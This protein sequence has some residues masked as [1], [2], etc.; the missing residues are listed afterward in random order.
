MSNKQDTEEKLKF[1]FTY[2]DDSLPD[3]TLVSYISLLISSNYLAYKDYLKTIEKSKFSVDGYDDGQIMYIILSLGL[4][5]KNDAMQEFFYK[6]LKEARVSSYELKEFRNQINRLNDNITSTQS[7][8]GEEMYKYL[9]YI[10][11]IIAAAFYNYYLYNNGSIQ[12]LQHIYTR[13]PEIVNYMNQTG[14]KR[15]KPSNIASI[16]RRGADNPELIDAIDNAIY[17]LTTP[18]LLADQLSEFYMERENVKMIN[19]MQQTLQLL[20]GFPELAEPKETSKE[21]VLFGNNLEENVKNKLIVYKRDGVDM[22]LQETKKKLKL[23]ARMPFD[24]FKLVFESGQTSE[25]TTNPTNEPTETPTFQSIVSFVGDLTGAIGDLTPE[26]IRV[27]LSFKNTF[28]WALQDKIKQIEW[29]MQDMETNIRRQVYMIIT[30]ATRML[31]DISD[32]PSVLTLLFVLNTTAFYGII[33]LFKKLMGSNN[34]VTRLQIANANLESDAISTLANATTGIER[35]NSTDSLN[36]SLAG[37]NLQHDDDDDLNS[38]GRKRVTRRKTYKRKQT[39]RK[40]TRRKQTRRK[41]T[42]RKKVR[43]ITRKY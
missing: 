15:H 4:M 41:Q 34:R 17:C 38:G 32:I 37:M 19:Q 27:S 26:N 5:Y 20:P 14:C 11:F 24:E 8:G 36:E 31:S 1:I 25:F 40:Q 35:S 30:E 33:F 12:T 22:D 29:D 18:T 9:Y 6:I 16:L 42:R 28:L 10:G 39:R 7:G 43:R 23:L 3:F 2:L 13:G 21:L